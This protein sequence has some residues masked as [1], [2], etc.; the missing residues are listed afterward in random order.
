MPKEEKPLDTLARYLPEGT[1]P[2]VEQ[3]LH[4]HKIHLTIT[5]ER[6]SILGD[7]RHAVNGKNHRISVNGNLNSYAF[8]LTLLHEIAHLLTFQQYGNRVQSHGKEWK[9]DFSQLLRYFLQSHTFPPDIENA[10][11]NSLNNPAAS[12]CADDD[13]TRVLRRYDKDGD[14]LLFVEDLPPASLFRIKGNRIFRKGEKIRKRIQCTEVKTGRVYLFSPVYE[15]EK[16]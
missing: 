15:V 2:M 6:S 5:R 16:V 8:L 7:Y 11:R 9:K 14:Q 13:L 10:V 1:Y 12:S 3:F 4:Q